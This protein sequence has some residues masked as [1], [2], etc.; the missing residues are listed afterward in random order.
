[1]SFLH[2]FRT[3]QR[4]NKLAKHNLPLNH[5]Y[6]PVKEPRAPRI[7]RDARALFCCL[8]AWHHNM[9]QSY[10]HGVCFSWWSLSICKNRPIVT[11]KDIYMQGRK[12]KS[13]LTHYFDYMNILKWYLLSGPSFVTQMI[14]FNSI[15]NLSRIV[16]WKLKWGPPLL[17]K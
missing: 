8:R 6:C 7:L 3:L 17:H 4:H 16:R 10:L 9:L 14:Q 11:F 15:C 1:M 5:L 2:Y 12:K 13:K